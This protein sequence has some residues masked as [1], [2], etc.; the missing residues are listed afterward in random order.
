MQR[1]LLTII[2]LLLIISPA[3]AS[4]DKTSEDYL[5]G[6]RHFAIMNPV[7]ERIAQSVI[8]KALKKETKGKYKVKLNSYTLSSMKK[9]IFKDL[10]ITGKHLEVNGIEIPYVKLMTITDYNWIDYNQTPVVFK[11]D[12]TFDYIM[13]LSENSINQALQTTEYKKNLEK[14]NKRA[15]PIFM[16]SDVRVKLRND[17]MHIIMEYN[18][19]IKPAKKNRTFMVSSSLNVTNSKVKLTNIGFDNAYGS[20]PIEKVTNLVNLVDPLSFTLSLVDNKKCDGRFD[21]AKIEDDVVKIDGK[22]YIKK[23]DLK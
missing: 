8:K 23:E 7:S 20:L 3:L 9:G 5:K 13:H 17:K 6:K 2:S 11:S 14:V 10:E 21:S 22:I 15:Y 18:F 16:I 19:P 12:M 4:A 1:L